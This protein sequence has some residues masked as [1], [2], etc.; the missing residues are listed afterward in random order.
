M[1]EDEERQVSEEVEKIK[2]AQIAKFP[3]HRCLMLRSDAP[4]LE[5]H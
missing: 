2:G 1:N 4:C 5:L 3:P